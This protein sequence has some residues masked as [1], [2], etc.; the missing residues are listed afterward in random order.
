MTDI[1]EEFARKAESRRKPPISGSNIGYNCA[2]DEMI[3]ELRAL[4][5]VCGGEVPEGWQIV[6]KTP[7]DEMLQAGQG[8]IEH[9]FLGSVAKVNA[10][11]MWPGDKVDLYRGMLA[12]SLPPPVSARE[13]EPS[14]KPTIKKFSERSQDQATRIHGLK[15]SIRNAIAAMEPFAKIA[16]HGIHGGP[17][18]CAKA[19]YE[20]GTNEDSARHRSHIP[21][22]AFEKL[23]LAIAALKRE[24]G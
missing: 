4:P 11:R 24:V 8:A 2:I 18:T 6:P 13:E 5:S 10:Y 21:P 7:T 17:M 12:A 19:V 9:C 20:D 15:E 1:R 23:R 22:E 16:A 14:T 3:A